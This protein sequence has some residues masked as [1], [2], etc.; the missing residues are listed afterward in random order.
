LK[1]FRAS[2]AFWTTGFAAAALLLV[3]YATATGRSASESTTTPIL[4]NSC[5]ITADVNRLAT[6]YSQVLGIEPH[7]AGPDYVEFRT[8]KGVLALFSADAQE[9]YIP[10]SARS[11]ENHSLVLE[12]EVGDVDQEYTRL[13]GVIK[14]WVKEPTTQ[15]WGTRSF[16]FRDPD[17]NLVDF[18]TIVPTKPTVR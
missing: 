1:R 13:R 14:T 5:L 18:F 7:R 17:G 2:A 12:F 16:Y 8:P 9:K 3:V 15:A 6:F 11:G 4:I 10:G